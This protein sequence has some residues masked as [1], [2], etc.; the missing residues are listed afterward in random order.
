M[1]NRKAPGRTWNCTGV[2]PR[3]FPSASN[4]IASCTSNVSMRTIVPWVIVTFGLF[5]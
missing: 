2:T 4:G 3:T 5:T 1:M